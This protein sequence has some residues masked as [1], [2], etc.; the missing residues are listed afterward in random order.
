MKTTTTI[1]TMLCIAAASLLL[2]SGCAKDEVQSTNVAAADVLGIDVS[3]GKTRATIA[4]VVTL[5]GDA[6]GIS[7]F[8]TKGAANEM[9]IDNKSYVYDGGEWKW[10]ADPIMWPTTSEAYPINFYAYYPSESVELT[11][12]LKGTY[13]IQATPA[14]QKDMLAANH[15]NV[16]T[17][18]TGNVNL[19]FKHILSK[20]DFK[21]QT[22]A[23]VTVEVQSIAVRRVGST[24]A[25]SFASLTWVEQPSS[26]TVDYSYMVAP[27][28]EANKFAGATTATKVSGSSNSLM[29]MP[30]EL[31][32]RKWDGTMENL[33]AQ[34]YLEV[35]YRI[36]ETGSGDDVVGYTDAANHPG[37]TG[38]VSGPLFAKVGY[39]IPDSWQ[40]G[41]AYTYTI[42]LGTVSSSGGK[43]IADNFMDSNGADS[44][45]PV[46][47][48]STGEDINTPNP[49][50]PDK[51][52]GFNVSVEDWG[53]ET[54]TLIE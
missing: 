33:S 53:D 25:F 28:Q 32:G 23:N 49:I 47:D 45:L 39:P 54:E 8:A 5:Q 15:L 9:F 31:N 41:K 2:A 50:F 43:L 24:G 35:V 51:P 21:V 16:V 27:L 1:S 42:S 52:I 3:T 12:D 29:L 7:V 22:G 4:D 11:T 20:I 14:A 44:G 10:A 30:Q 37:S 6:S 26:W 38:S 48:P 19:A 13:L 18:P 36:Y 17:R 46:L 40:M 34:S